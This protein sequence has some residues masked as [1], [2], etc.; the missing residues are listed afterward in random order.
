[1]KRHLICAAVALGLAFLG[2]PATAATESSASSARQ[3]SQEPSPC[4]D[5]YEEYSV[6]VRGVRTIQLYQCVSSAGATNDPY[7]SPC[8]PGYTE[9]SATVRANPVGQHRVYHCVA[10]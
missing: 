1:M 9:Y 2:S 10:Q 7:N 8:P 4:P 5:D 3:G 6:T